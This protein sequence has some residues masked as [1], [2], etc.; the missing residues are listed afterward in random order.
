MQ[1]L[2]QAFPL[3]ALLA[4]GLALYEPSWFTWFSGSYITWGL[5]IIMLSMGLTLKFDDFTAIVRS[6]KGSLVGIT[7]QY[8]IMPFLGW[9]LAQLF[10]LPP[11]LSVG[12]ILVASCPG[13]TASNVICYLAKANVALSVSMTA[14]STFLAVIMTPLLTTWLAGST[15]EVNTLGLFWGTVKVVIL[16]IS[17]G[18]IL[19]RYT[20]QLTS[21]LQA[22]SPLIAVIVIVLIV[23]SIIGA[24]RDQ[25][26]ASAF[27]LIAAVFTLHVLGFSIAFWAGFFVTGSAAD[28]RAISI[29]VGMQNSGLG[30]YLAR[31]NFSNPATA[32]PS[33][34]SSLCHCLIGSAVAAWWARKQVN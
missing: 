27:S 29:E 18:L 7:L 24:G 1:K 22:I 9:S 30:A 14:V 20:P 32:I 11:A 25:I 31:N 10:N 26:I 4:S 28:A 19:S 12:L 3:W 34:V 2:I 21:R 16:P 6:P 33:A 8:T 17:L 15:V 13:G 5:G 23:A